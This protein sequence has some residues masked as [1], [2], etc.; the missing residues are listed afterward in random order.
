MQQKRPGGF[1]RVVVTR[2]A[3]TR[4]RTKNDRGTAPVVTG[5]AGTGL[6]LELPDEFGQAVLGWVV[7]V[8]DEPTSRLVVTNERPPV[9]RALPLRPPVSN[10]VAGLR[11]V[12]RLVVPLAT[13]GP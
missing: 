9:H 4:R 7:A 10:P 6:E 2:C 5:H 12:E 1:P 3:V 13:S 11:P 8:S